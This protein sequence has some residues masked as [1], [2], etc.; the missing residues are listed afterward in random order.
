MGL[1]SK[2]KGSI[3]G[4]D[5]SSTA[6]KL[7]EIVRVGSGYRVES[8]SV[9]PLE[10]GAI[11]ENTISS[12]ENVAIGVATAM[13]KSKTKA[14]E[15]AVAVSG[16]AVITKVIEMEAGLNDDQRELQIAQEAEQHIPFP[17]TE[18]ALDFEV[19]RELPDNPERVE[20]LLVACRLEEVNSRVDALAA[21]NLNVTKVDIESNA[22]EGAFSLI[23]DQLPDLDEDAVVAILDIGSTMTSLSVLQNGETIYTREQLFG[24]QQLT[25]D[26]QRHYGL[27]LEEAGIAKKQGGLPDDYNSEVLEPFLNNLVQ[28]IT[29]SLQFFFSSSNYENVDYVVLAGGVASMEGLVELVGNSLEAPCVVANPFSDMTVSS[30]VNAMAL[31]ND[32]PALMVACGLALRSFD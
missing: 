11:V 7:L 25:E 20:V 5:L 19:L 18:V 6:V 8:Y 10:S 16:S 31:S 29:R 24:G 28:Q 2:K 15:A 30:K 12:A 23:Q 14:K 3:L 17:I 1:F 22:M 27:S 4:I 9:A 13:Q 21:A 26:I 32:A